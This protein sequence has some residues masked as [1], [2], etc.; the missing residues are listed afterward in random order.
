MRRDRRV[1]TQDASSTRGGRREEEALSMPKCVAVIDVSHWHSTYDAAYLRILRDLGCDIV[2]VSDR[3]ERIARERAERF[4]STPFT[5]YR[6][7][8]ETTSPE[9]VIALGRHCDMPDT[10]RFLIDA[11]IPFVMEK[12][13]G[14][15]PGTV[16]ALAYLAAE[17]GA[18]VSVPFMV[19]YSF[20]A[21][22][23]KRMIADGEFGRISHIV[24]RGIRPTMHR[25][26][27][28]DSPWMADKSQAGGGA[29]LNLGGHGFDMARF[30]TGEEPEVVS[31]VV[32]RRVQGGEVE[33]YAL[34][35]LR[36]PS[37]ILFHNEVGYTM[38]TW[39]ANQTDGEQKVAGE[40]MLLRQ[41]PG[42]LQ[43]LAPGR[44]EMIPKPLEW[45]D[46]YPRAVREALEAYGRGDPP[47]IPA[48][49]CAH[50]VGLI[51]DSYRAAGV[52]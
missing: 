48:S 35:T 12:P 31:A 11:G 34:A 25:Y 43:V 8:I 9:F 4:G 10:F 41:V 36:T 39:P 14:T 17:K 38:P 21:V 1:M 40:R 19:R 44:E 47:P 2:G 13:W 7:M 32:S 20:W 37:G 27:E 33:D 26:I 29:L 23:V 50:A 24:Y 51:F 52:R 45:Q 49:E 18:W 42:G 3:A 46:G 6:R 30:L 22:T 28:W 5:D 15:D 16:A